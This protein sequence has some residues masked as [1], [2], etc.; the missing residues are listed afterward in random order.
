LLIFHGRYRWDCPQ[1]TIIGFTVQTMGH[2]WLT[3]GGGYWDVS[4]V[5]IL[6][7]FTARPLG[8]AASL[9]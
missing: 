8:Q 1:A 5:S 9:N 6:P 7:F 3:A 4:T 2:W